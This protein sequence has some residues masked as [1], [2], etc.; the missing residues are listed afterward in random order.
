M[1]E[2][3]P[4]S[5]YIDRIRSW[6]RT[7]TDGGARN[8]SSRPDP[9]LLPLSRPRTLS[10]QSQLPPASQSH[11]PSHTPSQ[12]S[13][14]QSQSRSQSL[15]QSCAPSAGGG[16]SI[17]ST[18]HA[19]GTVFS[20]RGG[21][22]GGALEQ[23]HSK[24]TGANT[25]ES[26]LAARPAPPQA[27]G[28]GPVLDAHPAPPLD[29]ETKKTKPNALIRAWATVLQIL[30][31]SWLNVLL[32]F[33]PVGIIASQIPGMPPG[34]V[35][36]LNAIAIIPLAGLLGYATETVAHKMGDS[37]GALLNITFGNAVELIIL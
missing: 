1:K 7:I 34:A 8:S 13:P 15:S 28:T 16:T 23:G 4:D 22:D 36:A 30:C 3:S 32:V 18:S 9:N 20:V 11:T 6:A 14:G 5:S 21:S 27:E 2:A 25:D 26:N 37:I 33:V 24:E 35:F 17:T 19:G 31:H 29:G 12:T 10:S